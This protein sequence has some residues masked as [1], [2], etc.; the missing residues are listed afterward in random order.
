MLPK[1]ENFLQDANRFWELL[2]GVIC[3]AISVAFAVLIVW[4]AYLVAWR[5]PREYGVNDVFKVSTLVIFSVLL[6]IAVGFS[7]LAMR[8]LGRK[9]KSGGIMS[10]ILLRIWGSFFALGNCAVLIDVVV[11]KR[12]TKLW[13]SFEIMAVCISMSIAAFALA[14]KREQILK[15]E[16]KSKES[17]H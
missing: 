2:I 16:I 6:L 1:K 17:S 4:L 15:Q 13:Y 14:R 9:N 5:N 8:L 7:V 11:N 10:P 3:A 12:W